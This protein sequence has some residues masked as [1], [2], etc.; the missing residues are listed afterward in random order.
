MLPW[1]AAATA[2]G[3]IGHAIYM[4]LLANER[5]HQC[6]IADVA[7]LIGAA[8]CLVW[9]APAGSIAYLKGLLVVQTVIAG[10]MLVSMY[11]SGVLSA[12]SLRP[13]VVTPAVAAVL[14]VLGAE[15]VTRTSGLVP[16]GISL[17]LLYSTVF[18]V[19]YGLAL[20]ALG[21]S[22]FAEVMRQVPI[23]RW[24]GRVVPTES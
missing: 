24:L 22:D 18:V 14:G 15:L 3:A 12:R 6:L 7:G 11:L 20:R 17:L 2:A 8:V 9:L 5:Q 19:I 10:S 1:A 13:V 16:Q 23:D 21:T 4:L